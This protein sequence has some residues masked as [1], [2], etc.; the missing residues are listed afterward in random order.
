[1]NIEDIEGIGS[2]YAVRLKAAGITTVDA[3]LDPAERGRAAIRGTAGGGWRGYGEGAS[4]AKRGESDHAAD[5]DQRGEEY[6][7]YDAERKA[8]DG[9]D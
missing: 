7:G 3:R 4:D 9:L 2:A 8:G 6:F 1:M 5:R